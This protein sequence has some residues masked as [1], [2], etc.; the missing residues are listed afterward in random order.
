MTNVTCH[1][2]E[3]MVDYLVLHIIRT[4]K[5]VPNHTALR[6]DDKINKIRQSIR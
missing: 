1:Q 6:K 3:T 5:V 2:T 4:D